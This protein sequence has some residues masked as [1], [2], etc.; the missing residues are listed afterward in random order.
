MDP[1]SLNLHSF[2]TFLR[3]ACVAR[4]FVDSPQLF[5]K[6]RTA[7]SVDYPVDNC[8]YI[9]PP[10]KQKTLL[11]SYMNRLGIWQPQPF[12]S[13]SITTPFSIFSY[14]SSTFLR[15]TTAKDGK[16][17]HRS[18]FNLC[19]RQ[20]ELVPLDSQS[21]LGPWRGGPDPKLAKQLSFKSLQSLI[22]SGL[23]TF[24]TKIYISI[25]NWMGPYQRNPKLRIG[26]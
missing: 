9:I 11:G 17:L 8:R 3:V 4:K 12:P 21:D 10:N 15:A 23:K 1:P 22:P 16:A 19:F 25:K 6:W 18:L 7:I 14:V 26:Y 20:Q 5:E 24:W 2:P 13:S